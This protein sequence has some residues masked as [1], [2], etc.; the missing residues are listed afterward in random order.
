M[1]SVTFVQ[2]GVFV[3][4]LIVLL[5]LVLMIKALSKREPAL[6]EEFVTRREF[7]VLENRIDLKMDELGKQITANSQAGEDRV[8][9]LH[10]R[11]NSLPSEIIDLLR[12]TKGLL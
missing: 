8:I 7:I 2:V 6:T 1:E 5:G 4:C 12:K 3:G 9:K 11:L 10:N